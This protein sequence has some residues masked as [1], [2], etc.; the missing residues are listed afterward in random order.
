MFF[1]HK[2]SPAFSDVVDIDHWWHH[3]FSDH[4]HRRHR[5]LPQ[6]QKQHGRQCKVDIDNF[7]Y[8]FE[9]FLSC[10]RHVCN[11]MIFIS[12]CFLISVIPITSLMIYSQFNRP[13]TSKWVDTITNF[14]CSMFTSFHDSLHHQMDGP[15]LP[16][17]LPELVHQPTDHH[18]QQPCLQGHHPQHLSSSW[19]QLSFCQRGNVFRCIRRP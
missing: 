16:L 9:P 4:P 10:D 14:C 5:C 12:V 13:T 15:W 2:S 17:L 7:R 6:P 3:T 19:Q 11:T 18:V 1:F 8:S